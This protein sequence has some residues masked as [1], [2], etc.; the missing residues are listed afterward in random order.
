MIILFVRH[1]EKIAT[2]GRI[3]FIS[4]WNDDSLP[5]LSLEFLANNYV[6]NR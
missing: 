1:W 4:Y 3:L 6:N 5:L 2:D